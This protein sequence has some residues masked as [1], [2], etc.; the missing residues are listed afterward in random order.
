MNLLAVS[1]G[2]PREVDTGTGIVR[3]G[4]FKSPVGGRRW[5]SATQIEGDG[6]ADRTVHGGPEK[7]VYV[8]PSEH[9][10]VWREELGMALAEWGAFGENLTTTGLSETDVCIGDRFRIGSAELSVSQ[11]RMPCYKLALRFDRADMIKR[12]VR[13]DRSG[14]YLAVEQEGD[15]GAGDEIIRL[16]RDARAL[17][18]AAV[19]RLKIDGGTRAA[20]EAAASHPAL[21]AGW[22]ESF[23]QR[24]ETL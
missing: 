9:Y 13:V 1:V 2:L 11:P 14:F 15:V 6:Q 3:T 21:S 19:Y 12:F 17:A 20:I 5:V 23:R 16:S 10:V 4:I 18:V 7:A 22:R 24:L 8:Y